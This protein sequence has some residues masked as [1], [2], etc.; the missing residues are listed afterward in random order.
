[1]KTFL[2]TIG[3]LLFG[4]SLIWLVFNLF[5]VALSCIKTSSAEIGLMLGLSFQ[6][7]TLMALSLTILYF[8]K[9]SNFMNDPSNSKKWILVTVIS[10]YLCAFCCMSF[11]F[12]I[13]YIPSSPPNILYSFVFFVLFSTIVAFLIHIKKMIE[14]KPLQWVIWIF[15]ILSFFYGL[16]V[17][18]IYVFAQP[19]QI[20]RPGMAILVSLIGLSLI[21]FQ[22]I[23]LKRIR[24]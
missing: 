9:I 16:F 20:S 6:P 1:L 4:L 8:S 11:L 2:N 22:I 10:F 18:F 5:L 14:I 24:S 19:D 3:L 12:N 7:V 13:Y 15:L 17:I 23:Q 21:V